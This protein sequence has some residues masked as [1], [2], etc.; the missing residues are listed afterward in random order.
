M[1]RGRRRHGRRAAGRVKF[2]D[3]S[4]RFDRAIHRVATQRAVHVHIDKAR[5]DVVVVSVDHLR[6]F[7]PKHLG[8]RRH[9][10][11]LAASITTQCCSSTLCGPIT[12][13]LMTTI[14]IPAVWPPTG[15]HTSRNEPSKTNWAPPPTPGSL[16]SLSVRPKP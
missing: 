16:S 4:Q 7:G 15:T 8:L 9:L 12:R 14:M 5:R 11:D 3:L 2:R 6:V 10:L 13:P 1:R